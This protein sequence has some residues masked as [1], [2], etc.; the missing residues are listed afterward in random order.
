[1]LLSKK[2]QN[3]AERTR[4]SLAS[5][6]ETINNYALDIGIAIDTGKGVREEMLRVKGHFEGIQ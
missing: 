4:R 3:V 5:F 1:M 6:F 2:L